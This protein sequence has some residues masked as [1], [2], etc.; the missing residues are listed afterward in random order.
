[1]AT[2]GYIRVTGQ[3]HAMHQQGAV[4]AVTDNRQANNPELIYRDDAHQLVDRGDA[5]WIR[6]G[7]IPTE[8]REE[9]LDRHA[10]EREELADRHAAQR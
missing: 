4:L 3:H 5:E 6:G 2:V 1:M 8:T 7:E 9:R 10:G